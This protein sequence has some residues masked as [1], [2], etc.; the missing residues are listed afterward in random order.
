MK[1]SDKNLPSDPL[2]GI[3]I[4][5][6]GDKFRNNLISCKEVTSIYYERIRILNPHLHA[7]IYTDEKQGLIW[8]DGIDKLFACGVDLGPLMGIPIAIKDICSVNE[9]PTTN[10]SQIK[11]DD[12]T[13]PEGNL[14]SR[15]KSLGLSLIHISEPTRPY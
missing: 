6:L 5:E 14:V 2:A 11:S 4:E 1:N 12:I 15:L 3:S 8:A 7:Y 10:G 13:G 9:M